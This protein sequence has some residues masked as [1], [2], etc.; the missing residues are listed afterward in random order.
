MKGFIFSVC[1]WVY[2]K[3]IAFEIRA[4][5]WGRKMQAWLIPA[6]IALLRFAANEQVQSHTRG[7]LKCLGIWIIGRDPNFADAIAGVIVTGI[8]FAWSA[9]EH[10][11]TL[12]DKIN[13]SERLTF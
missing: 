7:L 11:D 4:R 5:I 8:G 3:V 1:L 10:S 9:V 6:G 12:R 13:P 2:V